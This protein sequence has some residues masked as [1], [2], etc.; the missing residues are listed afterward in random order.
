MVKQILETKKDELQ[1]LLNERKTLEENIANYKRLITDLEDKWAMSEIKDA[2]FEER[3]SRLNKIK[4]N[5]EAELEEIKQK[6]ASM[7]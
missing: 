7:S 2:E 5:R 4:N 3:K 1:S 6:I